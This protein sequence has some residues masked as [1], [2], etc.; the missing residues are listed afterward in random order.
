MHTLFC[1][2]VYCTCPTVPP[3]LSKIC[4]FCTCELKSMVPFSISKL[5]SISFCQR[6][7]LDLTYKMFYKV[8]KEEFFFLV[9][10]W[11]WI[12]FVLTIFFLHLSPCF[13]S[14]H[15][16]LNWEKIL[17][18]CSCYWNLCR[19]LY[20]SFNFHSEAPEMESSQHHLLIKHTCFKNS[21]VWKYENVGSAIGA[22]A[23]AVMCNVQGTNKCW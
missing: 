7:E 1:S 4:Y 15:H 17:I 11:L 12:F 16:V 9:K 8:K 19:Y 23:H 6:R 2:V 22:C 3:H 5:V 21:R 20:N 18:S 10:N 13:Q 14:K